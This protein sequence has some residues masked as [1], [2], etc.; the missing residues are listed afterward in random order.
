M[1]RIVP[2][3]M[4]GKK[5]DLYAKVDEIDESSAQAR[6]ARA[7][8]RMLE[9]NGWHELCG[10]LSAAFSLMDGSGEPVYRALQ[11][12]DYI[13][14]DLPGPGP[15]AGNGY[16]WVMIEAVEQVEE[17]AGDICAMRVRP[18][19]APTTE[20]TDTAH[21]FK[22]TA[23][24]TFMVR[25]MGRHIEASYHGRNELPNTKTDKTADNVR[26][27]VVASGAM[28]GFSELQWQVL[29]EAFLKDEQ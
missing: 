3:Q 8:K 18:V 12:N 27:A 11:V 17:T 15:A 7:C 29:I 19:S 6:Y 13:R 14:V 22:S 28:A 26:N 21:F 23:T 25:R 2:E 24:S 1:N 16:D 9:P 4:E 10:P 5:N 20:Q